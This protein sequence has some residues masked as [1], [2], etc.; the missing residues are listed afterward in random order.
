M[1]YEERNRTISDLMRD[2]KEQHERYTSSSKILSDEE[3]QKYIDDMTAIGER[4]KGG[5]MEDI[6]GELVMTFL[7]DTERVQKKLKKVKA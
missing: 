4:F 6:A 1:T 7:N 5:N 3:W 2:V